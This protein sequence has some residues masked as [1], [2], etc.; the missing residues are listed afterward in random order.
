MGIQASRR[1]EH[2]SETSGALR[3]ASPGA[4][5]RML[6][7]VNPYASTVSDRLR[8]LVV[9]ALQGRFDVDAID[10]QAPGHA[11]ELCRAAAN[12]G[13]DV[14]VAFGGDGTVNEAANRLLGSPTP[15]CCLP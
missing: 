8:N 12:D 10:T 14:L 3:F 1:G 15:L 5:R 11:V 4:R 13:Y 6:L 9:F 2:A 7:I